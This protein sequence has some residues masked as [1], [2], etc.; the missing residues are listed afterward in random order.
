MAERITRLADA[1]AALGPEPLTHF[2][3]IARLADTP[4]AADTELTALVA[5]LQ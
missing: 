4:P 5:S 3:P 1:A 2:G